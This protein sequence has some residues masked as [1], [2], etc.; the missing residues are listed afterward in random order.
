MLHIENNSIEQNLY[1]INK[2][3]KNKSYI[4]AKEICLILLRKYPNNVRVRKTLDSLPTNYNN[5]T[6]ETLF[7]S[8]TSAFA[9]NKYDFVIEKGIS[10]LKNK[11][12]DTNVNNLVAA[13]YL[14][15]EQYELAIQYCNKA[16]TYNSR[17]YFAFNNKGVAYSK[18]K[19]YLT[20]SQ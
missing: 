12:N 20:N 17:N 11:P 4:E 8:L 6:F 1:K 18:L 10:L 3:I 13:A 15:K 14:E 16:I 7:T 5:E 9:L 19:K 2:Y